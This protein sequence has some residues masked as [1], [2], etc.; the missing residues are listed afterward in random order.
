MTKDSYFEMCEMLGEEPIESEIPLELSD[1]PELVQQCFV[2]YGILSD[3]WDSM[4]GN[5]L[6]KDYSIVFKLF[7]IYQVSDS[8]EKLL[9]LDFM[10]H[11]DSVRSKLIS[12]KIKAK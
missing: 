2:M 8:S 3:N 5:Y 9:S 4:G 10:Q 11:I 12:D 1:F 7:D 6:G